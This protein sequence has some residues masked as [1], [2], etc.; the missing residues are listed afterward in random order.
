MPV[1][2]KIMPKVPA[3]PEVS[4]K[5][6]VIVKS[7]MVVVANVEVPATV[8]MPEFVVLPNEARP[9]KVGA[10]EKTAAPPLVEPVSSVSA[11]AR[12][13]DDGVPRKVATFVP[14]PVRL[15]VLILKVL[16][17]TQ[18]GTPPTTERT[19]PVEPIV[20]FA[21]VLAPEA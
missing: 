10:Y 18:V 12:L 6:R 5:A 14:R 13:A 15:A 20:R 19:L 2:C 3:L 4:R 16:V 17:A 8:K 9:V 11:A 1:V 21:K 7:V